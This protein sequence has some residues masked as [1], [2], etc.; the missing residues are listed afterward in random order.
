M[1]SVFLDSMGFALPLSKLAGVETVGFSKMHSLLSLLRECFLKFFRI[2][3][4]FL[5]KHVS[6]FCSFWQFPLPLS[7]IQG[8]DLADTS[9]L[10]SLFPEIREWL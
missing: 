10:H 3:T 1:G 8:V 4:P 9:L 5:K 2:P 7:K 6:V